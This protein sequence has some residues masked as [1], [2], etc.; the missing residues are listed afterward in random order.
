MGSEVVGIQIGASTPS[1][2]RYVDLCTVQPIYIYQGIYTGSRQKGCEVKGSKV[3]RGVSQ[4]K[5]K[6][7]LIMK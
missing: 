1:R 3:E 7:K 5:V 4:I 2:A 6:V